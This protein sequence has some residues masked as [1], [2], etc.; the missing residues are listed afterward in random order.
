MAA[1]SWAKVGRVR[2]GNDLW[3]ADAAKAAALAAIPTRIVL[4]SWLNA[5]TAQATIAV[6][7]RAWAEVRGTMV[8]SQG[9]VQLLNACPVVPNQLLDPAWQVVSQ[10]A[11][12]GWTTESD[13]WRAASARVPQF[14]GITYRSIGPMGQLI[15][16]AAAPAAVG[17]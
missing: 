5:T 17:A 15:V 1:G 8:N 9:R 6:G 10:L 4:S 11:D 14:A 7:I 13:A 3:A 12:L 2:G 16:E